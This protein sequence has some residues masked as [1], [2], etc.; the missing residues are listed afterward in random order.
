MYD[1][2]QEGDI[3]SKIENAVARAE[4]IAADNSHGYDQNDRWGNPNYDCSGLVIDCLEK[5]GIPVKTNGATYTG[6]IRKVFIKTGFKD[7]IKSVNVKTGSELKRG[8]VLLAEGKHVAFYCGNGKLVH[9]SINENGKTTGGK[10]GDQTGKEI[11]VRSYYNK[12]WTSVLRYTGENVTGETGTGGST[13]MFSVGLIKKGSKGPDVLLFQKI[14][15]ANGDY[16]GTLD[17]DYGSKCAEACKKIQKRN[18]PGAGEIDGEC[19]EK[20]WPYVLGL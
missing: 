10:S 20:T 15:K 13:Y 8:D 6:N 17:S 5:S 11:C 2:V 9:A 18:Q 4:S 19:G 16:T 1:V 14:A 12:P 7:V 3:V